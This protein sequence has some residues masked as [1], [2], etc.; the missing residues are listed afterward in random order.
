ME[1][2]SPDASK[3]PIISSRQLASGTVVKVKRAGPAPPW[4]EWD[5]D[6][7]RTSGP[8]KKRI[9]EMFFRRDPKIRAEIAWVVSESE[10]ESLMRKGRVKVKL[11]ESS[12]T[13]LVVTAGADQLEK[14]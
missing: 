5:D 3:K 1:T 11:R 2:V 9:Q 6:R 13:M 4:S 7:G 10:R 12:G 14:A 8:V